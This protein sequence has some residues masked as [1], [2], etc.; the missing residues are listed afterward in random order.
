MVR[1][2]HLQVCRAAGEQKPEDLLEVGVDGVEGDQE[3]AAHLALDGVVYAL[4][5]LAGTLQ[6][7]HLLANVVRALLEAGV[8]VHGNLVH[9]ADA[10]ERRPQ[11]LHLRLRGLAVLRRGQRQG[12]L[13]VGPRLLYGADGMLYLDLYLALLHLHVACHGAGALQVLAGLVHGRPGLRDGSL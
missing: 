9:G 12:L 5:C 1:V 4:E 3:L 8:L 6:V 11:V 7:L 13:Q 2:R 10:P